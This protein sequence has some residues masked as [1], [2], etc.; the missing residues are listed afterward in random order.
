[1]SNNKIGM[2]GRLFLR[3][4]ERVPVELQTT[5]SLT[6]PRYI[7]TSK[8]EQ[9][10][11]SGVKIL[12]IEQLLPNIIG[13]CLRHGESYYVAWSAAPIERH[14]QVNGI[15]R[16]TSECAGLCTFLWGQ[17]EWPLQQFDPYQVVNLVRDRKGEFAR[18]LIAEF[19]APTTIL[20]V[21]RDFAEQTP[22][23]WSTQRAFGASS[24]A[25]G[26]AVLAITDRTKAEMLSILDS[27]SGRV[28]FDHLFR[29]V[30]AAHWEHLF[31]D[32]YRCLERMFTT[33]YVVQVQRCMTALQPSAPPIS[34]Q[35]L[36]SILVDKIAWRPKEL[37]AIVELFGGC[38]PNTIDGLLKCLPCTTGTDPASQAAKAIYS[39]RNSIA[40]FRARQSSSVRVKS[41]PQ[42]VE[43][44]AVVLGECLRENSKHLG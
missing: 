16:D 35:E 10:R 15:L 30:T 34:T 1:M 24:L 7:Q 41:W 40:H 21:T 37:D 2:N 39:V 38:S 3:L 31:L 22:D 5:Q 12:S 27:S 14:Q 36:E 9:A 13:L 20:E 6:L 17:S 33:P 43:Q 29:A 8:E 25:A 26:Q 19:F 28:V 4:L 32:V 23:L 44:L 42:L 11:L 18:K